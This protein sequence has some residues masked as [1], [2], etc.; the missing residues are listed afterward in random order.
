MK[1]RERKLVIEEI[2]DVTYISATVNTRFWWPL[3]EL[4]NLSGLQRSAIKHTMVI[5]IIPL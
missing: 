5:S 1:S 4:Y 2:H 3:E